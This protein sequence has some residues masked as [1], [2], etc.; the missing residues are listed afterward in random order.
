M[1]VRGTD[2]R[3]LR[4]CIVK[5]TKSSVATLKEALYRLILGFMV[6]KQ[7]FNNAQ[8]Y[9]KQ[10]NLNKIHILNYNSGGVISYG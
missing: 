5:G 3:I 7:V 8:I 4:D 2:K 10:K 6:L 9:K 1:I